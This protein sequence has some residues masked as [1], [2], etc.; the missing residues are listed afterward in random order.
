[1]PENF[2]AGRTKSRKGTF[3]FKGAFKKVNF[4]L[5]EQIYGK[6]FSDD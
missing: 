4:R 2:L 1:M 5:L 3:L 6:K